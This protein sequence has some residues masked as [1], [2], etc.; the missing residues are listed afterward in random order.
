MVVFFE[1]NSGISTA[2]LST[3]VTAIAGAPRTFIEEIACA[4]SEE[5]RT[6]KNSVT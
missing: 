2:K 4:P 3:A 6:S 1:T 5:F